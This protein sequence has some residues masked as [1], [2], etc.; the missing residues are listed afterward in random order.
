VKIWT[1]KKWHRF[2]WL[3][4]YIHSMD[5]KFYSTFKSGRKSFDF[6]S[7]RLSMTLRHQIAD[8]HLSYQKF[9]PDPTTVE[10]QAPVS[11]HLSFQFL[12]L[13]QLAAVSWSWV[14]KLSICV[15]EIGF[16]VCGDNS[17]ASHSAVAEWW[18]AMWC[19]VELRKCLLTY[20]TSYT[21]CG[22]KK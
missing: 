21:G 18:H 14:F 19:N 12:E 11:T 5:G 9:S 8:L 15:Y 6:P 22:K 4:V 20:E 10:G 2:F 1:T 3:T 13:L 16:Y 17:I 7:V